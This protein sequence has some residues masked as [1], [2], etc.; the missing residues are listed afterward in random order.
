MKLD[1][2]TTAIFSRRAK[3]GDIVKR[4]WLCYSPLTGRV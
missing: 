1:D 3:N 2:G 4:S